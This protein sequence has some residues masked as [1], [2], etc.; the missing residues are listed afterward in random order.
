MPRA[1]PDR[2]E[3]YG[4]E[5]LAEQPLA[6]RVHD[7]ADQRPAGAAAARGRPTPTGTPR[8]IRS[9][10]PSGPPCDRREQQLTRGSTGQLE[11][12]Q[13]Q[14]VLGPEVVVHQR[15]VDPGGRG[16]RADRRAGVP[17]ARRTASAP[18]PGSPRGCR[19]SR[20]GVR[21]GWWDATTTPYGARQ[22]LPGSTPPAASEG[23]CLPRHDD[24][25]APAA[26][27]R[28][29]TNQTL[30]PRSAPTPDPDPTAPRRSGRVSRFLSAHPR[31]S[32]LAVFLFVLVAGFFGGPRRRAPST[33]RAASPATTPTRCGPSSASRPRPARRRAPA[34]CCSSTPR[35]ASRPTPPGSQEVTDGAGGRARRR[36]GDL[37]DHD[38]RRSRPPGLART[39]RRSWCSARSP[40]TPTTRRSPRR[41]S[42]PSTAR[43]TS[44]SAA[45]RWSASS[46]AAPSPRTSA[47]PSCSPSRCW[48]CCR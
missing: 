26:E 12:R 37:A 19:A 3:H 15:R 7:P 14:V 2:P 43:T 33:P 45:R 22:Y 30:P 27:S 21:V 44:P 17:L 39:A 35:R 46:S 40:P 9:P 31:R 4:Q 10:R 23:K 18:R 29:M 36:R 11:R 20:A 5:A 47:G 28:G 48:S 6:V 41:C 38:P 8:S 42:T 13:E 1:T 34:S 24:P 25:G 16:D 32:L